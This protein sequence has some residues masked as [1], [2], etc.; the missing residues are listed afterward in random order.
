MEWFDY[1]WHIGLISAVLIQLLREYES[2]RKACASVTTKTG[3]HYDPPAPNCALSGIV[4]TSEK[5]HAT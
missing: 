3:Q 5:H 4:G 2:V 1:V